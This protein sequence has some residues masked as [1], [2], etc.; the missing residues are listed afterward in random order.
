MGSAVRGQ[1][2]SLKRV[3]ARGEYRKGSSDHRAD[4]VSLG[5]RHG[6]LSVM[7]TL[8]ILST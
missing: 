1:T 2:L 5:T 7:G 6:F 3:L 8:C 4:K